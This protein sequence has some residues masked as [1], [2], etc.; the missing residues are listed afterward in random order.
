M[1]RRSDIFSHLFVLKI[2][3]FVC[4]T[5]INEKEAGDGP[6]TKQL[7]NSKKTLTKPSQMREGLMMWKVACLLLMVT[8]RPSAAA[9]R[10]AFQRWKLNCRKIS[11]TFFCKSVSSNIQSYKCRP[12]CPKKRLN[13]FLKIV[14]QVICWSRGW[15]RLSWG[16][17]P[18]QHQKSHQ[19]RGLALS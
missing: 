19:K 16:Q 13:L 6:F 14:K 12:F 3:V 1:S 10:D 2:V 11:M 18:W 15:L 17:W 5:K 8:L 4:K 9:S 7:Y